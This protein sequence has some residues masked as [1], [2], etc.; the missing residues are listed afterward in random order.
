MT[1][2]IT[3]T[4]DELQLVINGLNALANKTADT[5]NGVNQKIFSQYQ[6]Q[7]A[8]KQEQAKQAQEQAQAAQAALATP[9]TPAAGVEQI[10]LV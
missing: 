1:Y 4:A 8:A 2:Q 5:T 10:P 6:A 7:E 3:L 9:E